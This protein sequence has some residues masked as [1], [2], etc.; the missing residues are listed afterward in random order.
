[1][2]ST[3][4]D[5]MREKGAIDKEIM[6]HIQQKQREFSRYFHFF[7]GCDVVLR[8]QSHSA[9]QGESFAVQVFEVGVGELYA[10]STDF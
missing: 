5:I 6:L 10:N 9:F 1:M 8:S 7:V 4:K 2:R 3:V